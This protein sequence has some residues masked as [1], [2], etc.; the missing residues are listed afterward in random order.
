MELI[1]IGRVGKA[2]GLKGEV[3]LNIEAW[4]E[5]DLLAAPV[6]LVGEPAVPYFLESARG[7][8]ALIVK[9]EDLDQREEVA[10]LS[11]RPVFLKAEDVSNPTPTAP[12]HP[13]AHLVGYTVEAEGYEPLGPIREVVDMPEH[14]LALIERRGGEHYLPLHAD[15][16]LEEIAAQKV[17]RMDLPLGLAE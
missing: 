1:E 12:D 11:N 15:L 8:G 5:D 10:L 6:V 13:F 3:K 9:F 2:H 7:G 17:L 4:Y 16:I 14:Y